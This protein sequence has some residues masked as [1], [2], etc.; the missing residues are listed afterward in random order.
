MYQRQRK[1]PRLFK[2][3]GKFILSKENVSLWPDL[4][5]IISTII[6]RENFV[7]FRL[8]RVHFS[9][10]S[11]NSVTPFSFITPIE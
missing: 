1:Y 2:Q 3:K 10:I 8:L 5:K 11:L 9:S 7:S 4:V 6:A